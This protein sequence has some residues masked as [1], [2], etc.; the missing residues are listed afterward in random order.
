[1][2]VK[3]THILLEN[4]VLFGQYFLDPGI[5]L[6]LKVLKIALVHLILKWI[7]LRTTCEVDKKQNE[8]EA[9]VRF[10]SEL[11]ITMLVYLRLV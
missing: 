5:S 9:L 7:A 4:S 6:E 8:Y 3:I 2:G 11:W 10:T 1:M